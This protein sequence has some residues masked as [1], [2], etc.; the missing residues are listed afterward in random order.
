MTFPKDC[1][2]T[3]AKQE[4]L[5]NYRVRVLTRWK[6]LNRAE[7]LAG[8]CGPLVDEAYMFEYRDKVHLEDE[9][10]F[11]VGYD[12]AEQ[13][14]ELLGEPKPPL[15]NLLARPSRESPTAKG[16][17]TSL[18][19]Q[20]RGPLARH[21]L[22][23]EMELAVIIIVNVWGSDP[24]APLRRIL[25]AVQSRPRDPVSD[26]LVKTLISVIANDQQKRKLSQL[27]EDLAIHNPSLFRPTFPEILKAV[28]RLQLPN[29]IA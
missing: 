7:P 20:G 17:S 13:F 1:R 24:R 19:N 15:R 6:V 11:Y 29:L 3:L 2:G 12:C 18:E 27:A 25:S 21:P 22:N 23:D 16:G 9:G 4:I 5:K 10:T 26:S 8:C 14:L 28:A